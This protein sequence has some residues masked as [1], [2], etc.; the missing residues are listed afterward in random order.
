MSRQFLL[1][2]ACWMLALSHSSLARLETQS[3]FSTLET[4]IDTNLLQ[5]SLQGA[6][7][8][9][10]R[11]NSILSS[12]IDQGITLDASTHT[13][14]AAGTSSHVGIG[15]T[16]KT[17]G[18][19]SLQFTFDDSDGVICFGVI[20]TRDSVTLDNV[21]EATGNVNL[22]C[23]N[24]TQNDLTPII[25]GKSAVGQTY[26]MIV[27][28]DYSQIHFINSNGDGYWVGDFINENNCHIVYVFENGGKLLVDDVMVTAETQPE[29][30][31]T[32]SVEEETWS[33][34]ETSI[35]IWNSEETSIS[36]VG[37]SSKVT[38]KSGKIVP[39][40]REKTRSFQKLVIFN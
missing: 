2:L 14:T 23:S 27:D 7:A 33:S 25:D 4:S 26:V 9:E 10:T 20:E 35:E 12:T 24:S 28:R 29:E 11:W 13:I 17:S 40:Q 6:P 22:L 15:Q 21:L 32:S 38:R 39:L 18:L 31:V 30:S 37:I 1:L 8:G 5:L 19:G 3:L 16:L 34:E 36:F